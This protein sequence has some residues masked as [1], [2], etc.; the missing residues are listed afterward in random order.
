MCFRP[1]LLI[2]MFDLSLVQIPFSKNISFLASNA[3]FSNFVQLEVMTKQLKKL[4]CVDKNLRKTDDQLWRI[5]EKLEQDQ[6]EDLLEEVELL[7]KRV[8][9]MQQ[10]EKIYVQV[11]RSNSWGT[12][13]TKP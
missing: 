12:H 13:Y 7:R 10:A 9:E 6:Q 11:E 1:F 4:K 2:I 5:K 3:S 8:N